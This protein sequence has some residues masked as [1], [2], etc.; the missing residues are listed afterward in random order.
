M[1]IPRDQ[2][3]ETL[4]AEFLEAVLIY[5]SG[6]GIQR[7]ELKRGEK[8]LNIPFETSLGEWILLL[9]NS[10]ADS[11]FG[12]LPDRLISMNADELFKHV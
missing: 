11:I 9:G 2:L 1:A 4:V 10:L 8:G 5:Q 12:E 7:K 6:D 3:L